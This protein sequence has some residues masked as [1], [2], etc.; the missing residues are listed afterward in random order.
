MRGE[1]IEQ[2]SLPKLIL[3]HLEIQEAIPLPVEFQFLLMNAFQKQGGW[4]KGEISLVDYVHQMLNSKKR[5]RE[6][7]SDERLLKKIYL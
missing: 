2:V 6:E 4:N 3:P 1:S 7:T 5:K